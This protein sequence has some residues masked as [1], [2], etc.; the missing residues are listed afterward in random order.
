MAHKKT[1]GGYPTKLMEKL[2][3]ESGDEKEP[4]QYTLW[5]A[6][7]HDGDCV[8]IKLPWHPSFGEKPESTTKDGILDEAQFLTTLDKWHNKITQG[9]DVTPRTFGEEEKEVKNEMD[10]V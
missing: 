4:E 10:E 3:L 7:H 9:D 5:P 2:D 1:W 6:Q 8:L